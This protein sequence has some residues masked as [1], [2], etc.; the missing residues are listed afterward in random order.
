MSKLDIC[1]C[2]IVRD[3]YTTIVRGETNP[4]NYAE[5]EMA[6]FM[7]G[8]NA[9]KDV[10]VVGFREKTNQEVL[11]DL[12]VTYGVKEVA[13]AFPGTR[14]RL[15]MEAPDDIEHVAKTKMIDFDERDAVAEAAY[16]ERRDINMTKGDQIAAAKKAGTVAAE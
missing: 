10:K 8:D 15:P 4:M 6:R 12:R 13:K 16:Q 3:K 7:F 1:H 2:T 11:E 5:V 9:V 14:P